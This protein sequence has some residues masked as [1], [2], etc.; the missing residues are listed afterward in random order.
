ME[1]WIARDL[2]GELCLYDGDEPTRMSNYFFRPN[3]WRKAS[4]FTLTEENAFPE[5]TWENSP[6]KVKIELV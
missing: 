6:R 1:Y 5:I 3:P 2:N 4:C